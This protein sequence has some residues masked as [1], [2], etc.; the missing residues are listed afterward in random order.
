MNRDITT[1]M[2]VYVPCVGSDSSAAKIYNN[3]VERGYL[4]KFTVD[5]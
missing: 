1:I 2:E 3:E 4:T 5:E